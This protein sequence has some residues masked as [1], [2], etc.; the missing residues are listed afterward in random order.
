MPPR[1]RRSVALLIET[2]NAYARGLLAGVAAWQREHEAWSVFL[3]EQERGAAPPAWLARFD[4]D[5]VIARVETAAT[6]RAVAATGLP[7]VDVS[8]ARLLPAAPCVETDNAAIARAAFDHLADRGFTNLAF[9]GEARFRWSAERRD[10]FASLAADAGFPCAVYDAPSRRSAGATW[11]RERARLADWVDALPKPVGM[12]ACYDIRAQQVLDVCRSLGVAVPEGAAVVGVDDDALLCELAAPPLSSV[13]SDTRRIGYGA[14]SLLN[15]LMGGGEVGS[16]TLH[17]PPLG[18]TT[19]QSTDVLAI[20]DPEVAAAVRFIR[21]RATAGIDVN[22]VL[23]AVPL[24]R[25][26]LEQRFRAILGR[27]PHREIVRVRL[28]RAERLLRETDLSIA[29]VAARSGYR[30]AEYLSASFKKHAGVSPRDF[31]GGSTG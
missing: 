12:M 8:A 24:S 9:C 7:V 14:A 26:V 2:S 1:S 21:E 11:A 30:T 27:T 20:D 31:R 18:V 5:G 3:P 25:R 6:A 13:A 17:V 16:D 4:G 15:R 28:R 29:E 10:R 22:D 23:R 19:R